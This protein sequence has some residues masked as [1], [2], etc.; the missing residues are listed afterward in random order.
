MITKS[1]NKC[2]SELAVDT[3]FYANDRTC[4]DCR[5]ARVKQNRLEKIDYYKAY[6]AARAQRPDRVS[7][8]DEYA[9]TD[10]GIKAGN[11]AK[12]KW[13]IANKKKKWVANCTYN[14]IRDGKLMK[15]ESCHRCGKFNCRIEGHHE[16]YDR[17]LSVKWLCSRCHRQWHKING[18]GKNPV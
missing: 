7:A 18:E 5:K 3:G 15:S 16:D 13:T 17:P 1:C 8:R 11:A 9:K 14:A 6:D 10:A 2:A 12:M 4:K